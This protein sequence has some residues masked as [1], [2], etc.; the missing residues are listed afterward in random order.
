MKVLNLW[1]P[2]LALYSFSYAN[3]GSNN[4]L[5]KYISHSKQQ[6]F[7]LSYEK[8]EAESSKLRDSWISPFNISYSI[9]R[10]NSL[11]YINLDEQEQ[12][13]AS[14]KWNQPIFQSGGIYYGIKY[15]T[16][17][18]KYA[19]YSL[20]V[21]KRKLIKDTISV[22]M[23][24]KQ[25]DLRIKRQNLQIQNADIS[26]EQKK[27]QYLSGQLDSGFLD[28]AIIERNYVIQSLYDVQTNKER[29]ISKFETLSD[30]DYKQALIPELQELSQE[31]FLKYNIVLKMSE[32]EIE[33]NGYYKDV[34]IAK[35]LPKISFN[36]GYN[37]SGATNFMGVQQRPD[38]DY[39]NYGL[40]ASIPLDINTF[41]DLA[42]AR[43]DFLKSKVLLEDKKR[44]LRAIYEQVIQNINNLNKK[45]QLSLQ[46]KE[47]YKK[48]LDETKKLLDA[49]YKTSSDVDLLKNSLLM[50]ELDF[51]IYEIDKQL[52]LLTLYEMYKKD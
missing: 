4:E 28:N 41:D 8:N 50:A 32:S 6:Q 24:I 11:E 18:E 3:D 16:A 14:I 29:L 46:N 39:Y 43:V 45:K 49:G 21:Q 13:N 38:I 44:E 2:L 47:I 26:L 33:K 51:E 7:D 23:Q 48:L 1:I 10:D 19:N 15:A 52:E 20:D 22:L 31:E 34:T 35:Y 17:N 36:A 30:M 42:S 25:I 40:T 12:Q 5:E 9:S 27:E 37:W